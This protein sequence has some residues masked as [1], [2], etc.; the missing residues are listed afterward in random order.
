MSD[1]KKPAPDVARKLLDIVTGIPIVERGGSQDY[2]R[3]FLDGQRFTRDVCADRMHAALSPG[4][5]REGDGW[6][7]IETAPK[8]GTKIDLWLNPALLP[9][10]FG[11]GN[12][13]GFRVADAW[14]EKGRWVTETELG[15]HFTFRE[16]TITHWRPLPAPPLAPQEGGR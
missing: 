15:N 4:G 13:P 9:I 14:F 8:D 1:T 6:R 12:D 5:E 10:S 3:G 16:E 2:Q 11:V 7:P